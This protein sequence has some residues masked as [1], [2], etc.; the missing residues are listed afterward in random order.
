MEHFAPKTEHATEPAVCEKHG[1]FTASVIRLGSHVHR[2]S[3]P[4]C[5]EAARAEQDRH[6]AEQLRSELVKRLMDGSDI[7]EKYAASR[8]E[9]VTSRP[10][11]K[12]FKDFRD[13][14]SEGPLVLVGSVGTGKTSAACAMALA[15]IQA[16]RR[17]RYVSALAY[18]RQIRGTW[19]RQAEPREDQII[20][21][22]A[23]ASFLVIDELGAGKAT[24]EPMIQ[25]L[26]CA[27]YDANRMAATVI[28]SNVAPQLF[29]E[30]LGERVADRIRERAVLVTMSGTSLRS[31]AA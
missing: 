10:V 28:V 18:C 6:L 12:W 24:D 17:A 4:I 31:P 15:L 29:A 27:R 22:Y 11:R 30:R 1:A 19:G 20:E 8:F 26:I 3:C 14:A 2:T 9:N 23:Q 5:G 21:Q 13:G 25:E 16:G 7:P